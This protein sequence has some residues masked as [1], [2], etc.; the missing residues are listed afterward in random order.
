MYSAIAKLD[1]KPGDSIPNK[2][3]S[4]GIPWTSSPCSSASVQVHRFMD[5]LSVKNNLWK[6]KKYVLR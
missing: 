2:L 5:Y 4:P 1:V 3:T 6:N